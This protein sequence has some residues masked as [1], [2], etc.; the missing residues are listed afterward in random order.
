MRTFLCCKRILFLLIMLLT[1]FSA[2]GAWAADAG[3]GN[4]SGASPDNA[5]ATQQDASG[6][7]ASLLVLYDMG[8]VSCTTVSRDWPSIGQADF[9]RKVSAQKRVLYDTMITT[10]VARGNW[11]AIGSPLFDLAVTEYLEKRECKTM[12]SRIERL[13]DPGIMLAL[14]VFQTTDRESVLDKFYE[15][16]ALFEGGAQ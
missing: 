16:L 3:S 5:A 13:P 10:E 1:M 7:R 12:R 2:Q 15:M 11:Q 9:L 4:T 6:D 8:C 14:V